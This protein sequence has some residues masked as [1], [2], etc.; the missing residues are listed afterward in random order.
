[1]Y[2]Q[3][4]STVCNYRQYKISRLTDLQKGFIPHQFKKNAQTKYASPPLCSVLAVILSRRILY[5]EQFNAFVSGDE[6]LLT[7]CRSSVTA[8][9][10]RQSEHCIMQQRNITCLNATTSETWRSPR[11]SLKAAVLWCD[12]QWTPSNLLFQDEAQTALYK[13]PVRTAL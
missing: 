6:H 12:V 9:R 11:V 2:T 4:R 7:I 10:G 3:I 5:I 8:L 1:M 13:D